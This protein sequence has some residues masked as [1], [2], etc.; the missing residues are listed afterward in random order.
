MGRVKDLRRL[1]KALADAPS[2]VLLGG[3]AG[4]GKT[5]LV[6]EFG[7]QAGVR[8]LSGGCVE[9][10][11][12]GLPFAPFSAA[13]RG[14][15]REVGVDGVKELLPGASGLARLLP[16]FGD[17]QETS[18]ESRARM[19]ELVLTLLERLAPM[20]L[21]I[22]DAHWADRSSRDLLEFLIRNLGGR[23]MIV[24]TYRSDALERT[25]PLRGLLAE[26]ARVD[27][28]ERTEL[29]RFT[30]AETKRL[31]HQV[32]GHE[33]EERV[34]E[35]VFSRSEGNPL[36]AEALAEIGDGMLPDSLRDLLLIG[37]Q[38]LPEESRE[39]LRVAAAGGTRFEHDLLTAVGGLD[40]AAL[41]RALRPAVAANILVADGDGYAFRH[42]LIR[43]AVYDDLLPGELS[44]LHR[45][46][47]EALTDRP[48]LVAPGRAAGERAYHWYAAHELTK[49]LESAWE[50][51]QEAARQFAHAEALRM[52]ERVLEL[53]DRVPAGERL[54]VRRPD[55][56][57]RAV[58]FARLAG[59]DDRGIMLATEALKE[60]DAPEE[61]A[62]LLGLRGILLYEQNREESLD[63][64]RETITALPK[65]GKVRA[66]LLA[67]LG[68]RL[69]KLPG[70]APEA[71]AALAEALRLGRASDDATAV[72]GAMITLATRHGGPDEE[73]LAL[74][75]EV[76]PLIP[77]TEEYDDVLRLELARSHVLEGMGRHEDAIR[78][79]RLGVAKAEDFGLMRTTGTVLGINMAEPMVALGRWDEALAIIDRAIERRPLRRHQSGLRFMAGA[80]HLARGELD[81][82]ERLL[83]KAWSACALG[84]LRRAEDFL[85]VVQMEM[86]LRL[87]QGRPD[88][89]RA[90]AAPLTEHAAMSDEARYTWPA[91]V[92]AAL[93]CT[94]PAELAPFAARAAGLPVRSELQRAHR[95]TF[96]AHA[97]R[98]RG[99]R[100]DWAPVREAWE[101]LSQPYDLAKA[102]HRSA[103]QAAADGDRRAALGFL[104]EAAPIA[105]S[106]RAR[107]LAAAVDALR[108]RLGGSAPA[109][110]LTAR[111]LEVLRE[112][113]KGR[114]NREIAEALSITAKT[115]SVHVSNILAKLAVSSRTEAAAAARRLGIDGT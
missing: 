94:T 44:R 6:R 70:G 78:V 71:K 8:V 102:L 28:V 86:T 20:A 37:F 66:R 90:A 15:V 31:L 10:G 91:L 59:E 17:A 83:A 35:Q 14:L 87:A 84:S 5:R 110:G 60:A 112:L 67:Q 95:L 73:R 41:S 52:L 13:L 103:E 18:V 106:L 63:D 50:A 33:P 99:E 97:A 72:A 92:V 77:L 105:E 98:L 65:E 43:E 56:L 100:E 2:A 39:L 36:F 93:A 57:G 51:A 68:T 107:P 42:S 23:V 16:E 76:E 55:V 21:V 25:H 24:V 11:A 101:R 40:E 58:E 29:R 82:A 80:V 113:A 48:A 32:S 75:D 19:F 61:R 30:R 69:Y 1:R 115:A 96:A 22:E 9:L 54:P 114:S 12:D 109:H 27:I 3:E 53:W 49:A 64:L 26:L 74:F 79:A 46:Y 104:A 85:P 7:A 45:R 89:A 62:W 4:V 88:L 47:A 108:A 38:R 34:V 81:I 111:E